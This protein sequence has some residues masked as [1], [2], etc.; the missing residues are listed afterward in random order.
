MQDDVPQQFVV[1][2]RLDVHEDAQQVDRR[3]GNDAC[4]HLVFKRAR[5]HFAEPAELLVFTVVKVHARDKVFVGRVHHHHDETAHQPH[6]DQGK[7]RQ[8]QI[9]FAQREHVRQHMKDFLEKL[10]RQRN[11]RQGQSQKDWR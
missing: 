5:V 11:E 9:S 6:V 7:Q 8:D 10:D 3:N 1:G 4:R 2:N